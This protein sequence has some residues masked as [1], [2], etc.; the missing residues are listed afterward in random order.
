[1]GRGAVDAGPACDVVGRRREGRLA[2]HVW[3]LLV[4][5]ATAVRPARARAVSGVAGV[6]VGSAL[7]SVVSGRTPA[8]VVARRAGA[9]AWPSSAAAAY[10]PEKAGWADVVL[11]PAVRPRSVSA[12]A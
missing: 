7:C 6:V 2:V 8:P 4:S 12:R 5:E 1:M 9:R 10:P 11:K 3:R